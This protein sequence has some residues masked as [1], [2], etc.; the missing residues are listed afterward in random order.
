MWVGCA[1]L[2]GSWSC[3][4]GFLS[5]EHTE[6]VEFSTC[7]L[8]QCD[9]R[10]RCYSFKGLKDQC[11]RGRMKFFFFFDWF[12]QEENLFCLT[13]NI[14]RFGDSVVYIVSLILYNRNRVLKIGNI[15][16]LIF[17]LKFNFFS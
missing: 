4:M 13:F 14:T 3:L 9:T 7:Q 6:N 12:H 11:F 2:L 8:S 15:K 1:V 17:Y 5:S 16:I 10:L